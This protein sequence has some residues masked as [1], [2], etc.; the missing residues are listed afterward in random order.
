MKE[1]GDVSLYLERELLS[2]FGEDGLK[3]HDGRCPVAT[4]DPIHSAWA[5]VEVCDD[6]DEATVYLGGFT[7]VHFGNYDDD[8]PDEKRMTKIAID[9]CDFL[10]ELFN[11]RI[12]VWGGRLSGGCRSIGSQSWWSRRILGNR[13]VLWSGCRAD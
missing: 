9:V 2:R 7:H 4:F 11:D 12:E 5:P 10:T 13:A 3:L 8:L 1:R 6:W